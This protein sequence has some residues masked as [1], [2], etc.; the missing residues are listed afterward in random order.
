MHIGTCGWA[1]L[2]EKEFEQLI[3][4]PYASKLQAHAQLFS[5]VEVNSTFYRIPKV[6][7]VQKWWQEASGINKQFQFTVKAYQGITHLGPF[8]KAARSQFH[9]IQEVSEELRASLILFQTPSSFRLTLA[10]VKKIKA[11]F[12]EVERGKFVVVWEPR[13]AW[14]DNPQMITDV[15]EE[16]D[17][18][19]CVDPFRHQ[20]LSFGKTKIAYFR[21]HGF[22]KPSMYHYNFSAKELNELCSAVD[23]L[24]HT[25]QAA[26][27]FF[28]NV[29]CY[30]NAVSFSK[31]VR[32]R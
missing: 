29:Y 10:N 17:L 3:K 23:S 7:T 8:G 12:S 19:H 26:Y 21:L 13:G 2:R 16:C 30:H 1:Y 24:P 18:I 11:F 20:S 28:N 25:L 15:C 9:Q 14:L 31:L 6:T 27:V 22:G 4:K 32:G 5:V